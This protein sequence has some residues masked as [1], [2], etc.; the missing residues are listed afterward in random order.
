MTQEDMAPLG[1]AGGG[2]RIHS[3]A[4]GPLPQSSLALPPKLS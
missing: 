4:G 2:V 3:P 1:A